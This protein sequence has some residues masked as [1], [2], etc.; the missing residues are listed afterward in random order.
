MSIDI[1]KQ[2]VDIENLKKQNVNDLASLKELY[3]K[4]KEIEEKITQIKYID[5]TLAK[6]LKKEYESLKRQILDENIQLELNTKIDVTKTELIDKINETKSITDITKTELINKI[7]ETKSITDN[8]INEI[9]SQLD[10]IEGE[11][12]TKTE[13]VVERK[14]IDNLVKISSGEVDNTEIS[15]ARISVDGVAHGTLGESI[16]TQFTDYNT[17]IKSIV[18]ENI[19]YNY[20]FVDGGYI[21]NTNGNI[22]TYSGWKYTD[23]V[24][25][26]ENVK[27]L[28]CKTSLSGSYTYNAFY[29]KD[30]KFIKNFN[31]NN[32]KVTI[33]EGAYSFRLSVNG[34]Y[35]TV[36]TKAFESLINKCN[37]DD[38]KKLAQK[39]N[40]LL[41]DKYLGAK[42]DYSI[43]WINGGYISNAN[44]EMVEDSN[45]KYTDFIE[46]DE[47]INQLEI[48]TTM[49]GSYTYNGFYDSGKKYI[50][51]LNISNK[52]VDIPSNAKYIRLSVSK[53]LNTTVKNKIEKLINK[54]SLKEVKELIGN[55][56]VNDIVTLNKDVE[57]FV[58]Q[59]N[60]GLG[61]MF[62][63][64]TKPLVFTH[65]SDVHTRQELWDRIMEYNNHYSD[66]LDFSIHTGDYCG[67]NQDGYIDLYS[68]GTKCNV[69]VYN[70][71]GNHDTYLTDN[72]TA[73]KKVTHD[74]LF[75]HTDGWT[76]VKFM[77]IANSMTYYKDFPDKKI[78]L[79]V[80]DY[81]YDKN[82]QCTWLNEKL[83]EAKTNGYHVV[84]CMH[85]MTNVIMNK[86]ETNFQTIDKFELLGGNKNSISKFDKVIGDWIKTGGVHVA[87]FAGH[88]HSDFIGY[89]E[90][91]VLNICVQAATDNTIWTDG[92]RVKN[93]KTWDCFNV[94]S[95]ETSTGT[96]KLIRIGNNSDHY[97]REKKVLSYNYIDKKIITG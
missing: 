36:V 10:I 4:L 8:T 96:L 97:L 24:V 12:A 2:Q 73:D 64:K 11:K 63:D 19:E 50:G 95:V 7:N 89:T 74:L 45:W 53:F 79:I 62:T 37:A 90:N 35:N 58:I 86:L 26:G 88:E 9:N 15:D 14:R 22:V 5:N 20:E 52:V 39:S 56:G 42:S 46:I 31:V 6:K 30:K 69:T 48:E 80:L 32:E 51:I 65:F 57:P 72:S 21:D 82:D 59:A 18:G 34:D 70:C 13:V 47:G 75:N 76:N 33:P 40:E 71:V 78:R 28:F 83:T 38:V 91:G 41:I 60:E 23:Y 94:V 43:N 66:Y 81:Y 84:T 85:E 44:G 25:I 49:T 29:D 87:N 54:C 3:R 17:K 55:N 27:E 61:Q 92:K 77:N 16:R 67:A 93:T 68:N 1:N